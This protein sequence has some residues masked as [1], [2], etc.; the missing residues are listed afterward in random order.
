M[1]RYNDVIIDIKTFW[2]L[3][4]LFSWRV[5][6]TVHKIHSYFKVTR[7]R[8]EHVLL[9]MAAIGIHA[10]L[11]VYFI[12]SMTLIKSTVKYHDLGGSGTV[13]IWCAV[14]RDTVKTT[15][16]YSTGA[17]LAAARDIHRQLPTYKCIRLF[18]T[19]VVHCIYKVW[20][21]FNYS[22]LY[23]PRLKCDVVSG[24]M[25]CT[26]CGSASMLCCC[27]FW[28]NTFSFTNVSTFLRRP[29]TTSSMS[30]S[31]FR[32]WHIVARPQSRRCKPP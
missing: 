13:K 6:G 10:N 21:V 28:Y 12:Y 7:T 17:P 2:C 25:P 5:I 29:S 1:C 30:E 14:Y 3:F 26:V 11:C 32:L 18:T 27:Q 22:I 20:P 9:W 19:N 24:T 8:T 16:P 15:H 23:R 4:L 31:C